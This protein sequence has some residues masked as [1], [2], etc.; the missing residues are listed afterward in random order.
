MEI[1]MKIIFYIFCLLS[2]L[3]DCL[4]SQEV[5]F[6]KFTGPYFG[7]KPPG[8]KPEIFA[9]GIVS[10]GANELNICFS[11]TGDEMF[12]FVTGPAY[13]P[14]IILSSRIEN[15]T[16]A[17]PT[18]LPFFDKNRTDSY[19]FLTPDGN[20]LFFNSSRNYDGIDESGHGRHHE[21][22]FVERNDGLWSEP[23]KIDFGGEY[24]GIGTFPSVASSGNI[25]FN[26]GFDR[27]VSD[28]YY[29]KY[30]N[31][32][33]STPERLSNAVNSDDRDF[34]PYIAPDESYLLFDS[35]REEDSFGGQD[36]F[37]SFRDEEGNWGKALNIG[38]KVNTANSELRPYVTFD[39]KYLFFISSRMNESKLSETS[40]TG[41]EIVKLINSPGNGLQ[42]I[43][44]IDAG[45][46]N[47]LKPD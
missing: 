13:S 17:T 12:Y 22:W 7:Q 21:I 9:P 24:R 11:P 29:S 25:Y 32:I 28:I 20:K 30:E 37:I 47:E 43:Y 6:K 38:D 2:F 40:M 15:G 44:W 45:F 31:G 5:E 34:H 27:D 14:R 42:D 36:I 33:Y 41:S 1:K 3:S 19:P 46:I 26:A 10:T 18:E 4:Y 39:G 16:W 35:F 8:M 23:Q